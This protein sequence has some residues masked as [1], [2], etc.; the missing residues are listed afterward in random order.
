MRQAGIIAAAGIYALEHHVDRLAEDHERAR[1]LARGLAE[2]PGIDVDA[3][4]VETNIVIFDSHG[5]PLNGEEFAR[6]T[7]EH[8]GVRFSILGHTLLPGGDASG[9]AAG[10]GGEGPR[11]R[12]HRA[13]GDSRRARPATADPRGVLPASS[14][15]DIVRGEGQSI[16]VAI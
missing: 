7:L 15:I 9:S 12:R 8:A 6:R 4:R 16:I 2:L 13:A 11:G 10:C 1:E 3:E 14:F 5:T